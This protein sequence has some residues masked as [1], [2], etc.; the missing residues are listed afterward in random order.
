MYNFSEFPLEYQPS[1]HINLATVDNFEI[2]FELKKT[3]IDT[4][5]KYDF[6]INIY[7]MVYKEVIFDTNLA[8]TL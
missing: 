7:L 8:Y 2:D 6:D 1:G 4:N 5:K 3:S